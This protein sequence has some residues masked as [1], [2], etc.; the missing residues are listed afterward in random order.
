MNGASLWIMLWGEYKASE[1][2]WERERATIAY[3][4]TRHCGPCSS[5]L[6]VLL[7][8]EYHEKTKEQKKTVRRCYVFHQKNSRYDCI[9]YSKNDKTPRSRPHAVGFPFLVICVICVPETPQ[10]PNAMRICRATFLSR[11]EK[12]KG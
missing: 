10:T 12:N 8:I 1:P 3:N 11:R 7:K 4:M 6:C 2:I 9:I 5:I